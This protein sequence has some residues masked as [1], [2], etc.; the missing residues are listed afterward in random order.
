MIQGQ[1][2]IYN[3]TYLSILSHLRTSAHHLIKPR[4]YPIDRV[5]KL[6]FYLKGPRSS[7]T[8]LRVL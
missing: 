3:F 2:L 7:T 1:P 8:S 5:P 4:L 6:K